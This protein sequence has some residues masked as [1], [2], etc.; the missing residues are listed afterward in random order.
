[1]IASGS[2]KRCCCTTS[3]W[4]SGWRSAPDQQVGAPAAQC[5]EQDVV[6]S[7]ED[8]DLVAGVRSGELERRGGHDAAARERHGADHRAPG[9]ET[10][11]RIDLRARLGELGEGEPHATREAFGLACRSH[12][13]CRRLEQRDPEPPLELPARRGAATAARA[14]WPAQPRRTRR[15]RRRRRAPA[16]AR[17]SWRGP[18]PG[19][20]PLGGSRVSRPRRDRRESAPRRASHGR[21]RARRPRSSRSRRWRAIQQPRAERGFEP[22][23]DLTDGRL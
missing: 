1:M 14:R 4:G 18:G 23:E 3:D 11:E 7:L 2:S 16:A 5:L 20:S 6:R 17:S 19:R 22:G 15:A 10:L 13:E 9:I 12:A 21:A 8:R